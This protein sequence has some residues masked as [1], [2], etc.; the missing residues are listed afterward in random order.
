M[1]KWII[2]YWNYVFTVSAVEFF[3]YYL[4]VGWFKAFS[5]EDVVTERAF[6][7][8]DSQPNVLPTVTTNFLSRSINHHT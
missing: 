2:L 5:M 8:G 3:I 6:K 1:L 7:M 4:C